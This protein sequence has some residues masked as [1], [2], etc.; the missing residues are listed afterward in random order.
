M[1]IKYALGRLV[2]L[3][4]TAC[5]AQVKPSA[6]PNILVILCD[7]LGY[8][9]VGFNGSTDILTPELDKLAKVGTIMTSAYVAHTFCGPCRAALFL[10]K[11]EH[12]TIFVTMVEL[13]LVA[14]PLRKPI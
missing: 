1:K 4:V 10:Q 9:D 3:V 12:R 5:V 2:L 11:L 7:D 13:P 8:A 14:Y 6:K